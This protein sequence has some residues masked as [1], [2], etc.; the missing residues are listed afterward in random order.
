MPHYVFDQEQKVVY[1]TKSKRL[2]FLDSLLCLFV[3]YNALEFPIS[4]S[5][6]EFFRNIREFVAKKYFTEH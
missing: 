3:E 2:N 5:S 1:Y 6:A 4:L